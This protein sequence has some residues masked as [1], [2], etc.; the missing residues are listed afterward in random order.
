MSTFIRQMLGIWAALLVALAS[1]PA[2]SQT[3]TDTQY[4]FMS[5]IDIYGQSSSGTAPNVLVILDNSGN[6][7]TPFNNEIKALTVPEEK[8]S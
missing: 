6:W 2:T 1:A 8:A 4:Q 5:D 3:F 7:S